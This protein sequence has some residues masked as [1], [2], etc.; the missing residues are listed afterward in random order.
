MKPNSILLRTPT[1][2]EVPTFLEAFRTQLGDSQEEALAH[3]GL[4]WDE[5]AALFT[6][7]GELRA[8]DADGE[9]AGF[10]WIELRDRELHIHAVILHPVFRG[11]GIGREVFSEL[12]REYSDTINTIELGVQESNQRAIGFYEHIGFSS[13]ERATAPGFRIMTKRC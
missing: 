12:Q 6:S 7:V 11:R 2:T 4:T 5:L 13:M 10:V 1:A 3:L 8:I 9:V